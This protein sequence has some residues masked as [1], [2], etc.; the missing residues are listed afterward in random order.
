MKP[1][2]SMIK[3]TL[4]L[5]YDRPNHNGVVYTK[6]AI[7]N[8]FANSAPYLPILIRNDATQK[9]EFIGS[10]GTTHSFDCDEKNKT[11]YVT[12]DGNIYYAGAD[13]VIN[14]MHD[15]EVTDFE[16]RSISILH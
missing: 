12:I 2:T 9:T 1:Q 5:P 10:T 8:A 11:C 7:E 15:R 16:I 3:L 6:E 14:E 4:A 13:I